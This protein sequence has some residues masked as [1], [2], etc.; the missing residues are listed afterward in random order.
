MENRDIVFL[1]IILAVLA[2]LAAFGLILT[3]NNPLEQKPNTSTEFREVIVG[4]QDVLNETIVIENV[5]QHEV[6]AQLC[7]EWIYLPAQI[8]CNVTTAQINEETGEETNVTT[9]TTCAQNVPHFQEWGC[10]REVANTTEV[11]KVKREW[12][13]VPI[14]E[15]QPIEDIPIEEVPQ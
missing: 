14:I 5:T 12:I 8:P 6:I 7:G 15:M 11:I 2:V 9:E 1:T 3:G 13:K 10:A 4:Y